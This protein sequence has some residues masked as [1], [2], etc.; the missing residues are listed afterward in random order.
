MLS[1]RPVEQM[2]RRRVVMAWSV[3]VIAWSHL[4]AYQRGRGPVVVPVLVTRSA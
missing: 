4:E 2:L 1:S 3:V